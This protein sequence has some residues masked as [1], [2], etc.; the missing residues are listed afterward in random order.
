MKTIM[1]GALTILFGAI[2]YPF[3]PDSAVLGPLWSSLV[4]GGIGLSVVIG[5]LCLSGRRG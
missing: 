2:M 1:A 5:G 4:M 3:W